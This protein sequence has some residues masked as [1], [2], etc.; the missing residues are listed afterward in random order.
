MDWSF[1]GVNN[2]VALLRPRRQ[3]GEDFIRM[4]MTLSKLGN[5]GIPKIRQISPVIHLQIIKRGEQWSAH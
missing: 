2:C 3:F 1:L 5:V 4:N